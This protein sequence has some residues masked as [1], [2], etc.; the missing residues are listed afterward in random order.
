VK[1][2]KIFQQA[3]SL[4]DENAKLRKEVER[5]RIQN[6]QMLRE[7]EL[8]EPNSARDRSDSES[9]SSTNQLPSS[10]SSDKL[11]VEQ[12]HHGDRSSVSVRLR[13]LINFVTILMEFF[14][15]VPFS[16]Q[17]V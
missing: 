2:P 16:S 7:L 12:R 17:C 3:E 15:L 10:T 13:S 9:N 14:E 8:R 6:E 1:I 11:N 5:L 4:V